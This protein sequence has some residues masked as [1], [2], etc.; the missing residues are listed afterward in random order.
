MNTSSATSDTQLQ[1]VWS[2]FYS[3]S[4]EFAGAEIVDLREYGCGK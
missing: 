1:Q 2:G 3:C 4:T